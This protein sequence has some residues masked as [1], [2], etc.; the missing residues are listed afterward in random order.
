MD[1][2][3]QELS[4]VLP[5]HLCDLV[6][7]EWIPWEMVRRRHGDL[8]NDPLVAL[9]DAYHLILS[10]SHP[11]EA[12]AAQRIPDDSSRC[13]RCGTCCTHMRPGAVS[14]ATYR[15]WKER[16]TLA[17]EFYMA[18]GEGRN[19]R[20]TCW[21][22][23]GVR[24]RICPLLFRNLEDGRPFCSVHHLGRRHRPSACARFQPNPPTCTWGEVVLVP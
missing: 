21:F 4:A 2:F 18:V 11:V 20:Y 10:R 8:P 22:F 13:L 15:R 6:S 17:G 5:V 7:A 9:F 14:A 16:G 1:L 12:L 3:R 23:G 24:L 19:R